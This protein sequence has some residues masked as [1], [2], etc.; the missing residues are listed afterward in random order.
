MKNQSDKLRLI[1][2]LLAFFFGMFGVHRFYVGQIGTGVVQLLFTL[3]LILSFVTAIWVIIDWIIILS[4][5]FKDKEG[6]LVLKWV[7]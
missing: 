2:F 3:T 6:K 4:G 7:E 1:A 5:A